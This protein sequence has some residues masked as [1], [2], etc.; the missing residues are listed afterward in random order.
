M[1]QE[2]I[3]AEVARAAAE[4]DSVDTEERVQV[5]LVIPNGAGN[6]VQVC[7]VPLSVLARITDELAPYRTQTLFR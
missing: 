5:G 1:S 6:V 2:Q 4:L 3:D 7:Q